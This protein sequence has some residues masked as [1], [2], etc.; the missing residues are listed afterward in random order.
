MGM[1]LLM[2]LIP[3]DEMDTPSCMMGLLLKYR[4][5]GRVNP[6]PRRTWDALKASFSLFLL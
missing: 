5:D 1:M 4:T 6:I 2:R 3:L